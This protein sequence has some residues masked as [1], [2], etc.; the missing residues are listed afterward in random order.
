MRQ[1]CAQIQRV[2]AIP[3]VL[4]VLLATTDLPAGGQ[5]PGSA[6]AQNDNKNAAGIRIGDLVKMS[7]D[8]Q[9]QIT[10]RELGAILTALRSPTYSNGNQK[11]L[12]R[13]D[14]D[15]KLA[16]CTQELF[17]PTAGA[18]Y[19]TG[20]RDLAL[21]LQVMGKDYPNLDLDKT[22]SRFILDHCP[23]GSTTPI[24]TKP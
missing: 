9:A 15:L 7:A 22:M 24:P 17:L 3:M 5:T 20:G 21:E 11:S 1:T 10:T 4:G 13:V 6:Q 12:E 23:A 19:T 14:H 2:L 18:I 16:A 8:K